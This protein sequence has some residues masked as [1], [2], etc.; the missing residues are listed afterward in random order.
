LEIN[1]SFDGN[2]RIKLEWGPLEMDYSGRC[3]RLN[4]LYGFLI[5]LIKDHI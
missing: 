2:L 3:Q 4:A 5:V 1:G